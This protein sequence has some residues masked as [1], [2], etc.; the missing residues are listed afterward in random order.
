MF[1]C[2]QTK[3][4][5]W[6]VSSR[7]SPAGLIATGV[8]R[9]SFVD[10]VILAL[11]ALVPVLATA[12]TYQSSVVHPAAKVFAGTSQYCCAPLTL[13]WCQLLSLFALKYRTALRCVTVPGLSVLSTLNTQ[14]KR[15]VTARGAWAS[16]A[17]VV[18]FTEIGTSTFVHCTQLD[19]WVV[20]TLL[21][22]TTRH[23]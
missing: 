13:C 15:F 1:A 9:A 10:T 7:Y 20:P 17:G 23:W 5:P 2:A 19:V 21:L 22:A 6:T 8:L 3:V 12:T 18:P 4:M 11:V 14:L 16:A